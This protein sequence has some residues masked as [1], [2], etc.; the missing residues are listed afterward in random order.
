MS[1][2]ERLFGKK[3]KEEKAVP[4]QG[5]LTDDEFFD[6]KMN[7]WFQSKKDEAKYTQTTQSG[8]LMPRFV[9][10]GIF[11]LLLPV[12]LLG[13]TAVTSFMSFMRQPMLGGYV[14]VWMVI[15]GVILIILFLNKRDSP[16]GGF[17][18]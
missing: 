14:P 12:W 10:I 17:R 1:F 5:M 8:F 9:Y 18:R 4:I 6:Y 13:M 3:K 16:S 2:F 11:L 7:K 15:G